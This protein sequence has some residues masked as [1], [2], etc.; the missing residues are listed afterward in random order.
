MSSVDNTQDYVDSVVAVV[1]DSGTTYDP[2]A[3]KSCAKAVV[4]HVSMHL[5]ITNRQI[6]FQHYSLLSHF[7]NLFVI[8]AILSSYMYNGI[9]LLH[10]V[11]ITS[12]ILF[13]SSLLGSS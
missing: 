13:Y 1:V 2:Y 11:E 7:I 9:C 8:S 4:S 6:K 3:V 10:T 12:L 5:A